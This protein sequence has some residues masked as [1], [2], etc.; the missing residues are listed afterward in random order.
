MVSP[1]ELWPFAAIRRNHA[2]EH[3]TISVLSEGGRD[4]RLVGRSD[5]AG[6]TLYGPLDTAEVKLAV[7]TA[8][9]RLRAG[10]GQLAIHPHCGTNLATG[11][12]LAGLSVYA[13]L[14][15]K[16]RSRLEKALQ[17]IFGLA[18]A[19]T[20]AQPLGMKL[21]EQVTTSCDVDSLRVKDIRRLQRGTIIVHRIDTAQD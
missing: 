18:A 2:L 3:A 16:R 17:L 10:E 15:G 7:S 14:R 1:L 6:F 5:W 19:L 12:V 11:Y 9:Q 8:L 21:Q 20:L 13:A 4:L